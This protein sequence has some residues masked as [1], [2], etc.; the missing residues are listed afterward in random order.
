MVLL[1]V[2]NRRGQHNHIIF[3]AHGEYLLSR[4][5]KKKSFSLLLTIW[6]CQP[7]IKM[8]ESLDLVI[9][10][11]TDDRQ[12]DTTDHFTPCACARGNYTTCMY[13]VSYRII[14]FKTNRWRTRCH[15]GGEVV[16]KY[17]QQSSRGESLVRDGKS[18]GTPPSVWNTDVHD[19]SRLSLIWMHS[20][21]SMLIATKLY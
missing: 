15:W 3:S 4:S 16:L 7:T 6:S 1:G 13:S 19:S 11:L 8:P 12:T 17:T 10:V 21:M 2:V 9:F 18:Q 20:P 14:V 5:R